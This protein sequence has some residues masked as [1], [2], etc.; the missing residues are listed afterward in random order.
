ME[1]ALNSSGWTIAAI[2]LA[3]LILALVLLIALGFKVMDINFTASF[4][5]SADFHLQHCL[6]FSQRFLN[7]QSFCQW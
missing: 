6:H 7:S 1:T 3:R 4:I 5:A 2:L